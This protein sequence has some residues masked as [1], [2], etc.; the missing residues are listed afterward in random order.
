[1]SDKRPVVVY[2]ASGF[3]ARLI[4]EFLREYNVPFVA[5]GRNRAKIEEV[6]SHVPGIAT[7]DYEIVE[8]EHDVDALAA[9]FEG[10]KVVS[11]SVGPCIYYAST[12]AEAALKAGCHYVDTGGETPWVRLAKEEWGTKFAEAGLL[13]APAT[14]YMS[15]VAE[16]CARIA[17]ERAPGID[18]LEILSMFMGF[19]TYG[20]TQTIFGQRQWESIYL[21]QNEYREWPPVTTLELTIPSAIATQ[22]ALPWGGFPH[23]VWFKDHPQIANVKAFGGL[24]ERSIMEGI[25]AGQ[26]DY[27]EKLR[28]LPAE[29]QRRI[30]AEIADSMQPE[31]PP[32]ENRRMQRT[33][34]VVVGRGSTET[35]RVYAHGHGAYLQTGLIQAFA[36]HHL[37]RQPPRKGR[38]RRPS[39]AQASALV[40]LVGGVVALLFVFVPGWKPKPPPDVAKATITDINA[41]R[42][43][44][45]K[46]YLQRQAFPIPK[47]LTPQFL[48]RRGVMVAFH[49]EITGLSHK[50]LR[51]RWEL[52]NA[53]TNDLVASEDSAYTLIPST[54]DDA[55]DWSVWM[56]AP[57][58]GRRYYVTVTI[59]QPKGPPFELKHFDSPKF[60][61]F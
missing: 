38:F 6:L 57:K 17:M 4:I 28:A 5:A 44:T 31:T 59:Y 60:P 52:S 2:G 48:A 32:R 53:V 30:L 50:K 3:S 37:V 1:M 54:N 26:R 39:L 10:A 21:E 23:P 47:G 41:V 13:L 35:I 25:V 9:L 11:N 7:A 34:D 24:L 29:E 40:A 22:L 20:S 16:A 33:V 61:G 58:K 42:P 45:F 14:A 56:A 36:L 55:G 12:V 18:S 15:A 49:Y 43:V 27:Q 19:P 8:V 51:L 46:R